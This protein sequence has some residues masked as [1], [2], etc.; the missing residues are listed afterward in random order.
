MNTE[1]VADYYNRMGNNY[2]IRREKQWA[3]IGLLPETMLLNLIKKRFNLRESFTFL[4]IG[5]GYG[6]DLETVRD[7][8]N[9]DVDFVSQAAFE[10]VEVSSWMAEQTRK[11]GFECKMGDFIALEGMQ[12][13][14]DFV[15][16]N[17]CLMHYPLLDVPS[18]LSVLKG[19]LRPAGILGIGVKTMQ[20]PLDEL[21]VETVNKAH[22]TITV[23]RVMTYFDE[24]ALRE[25]LM[26][27]GCLL[28][29]HIAIPS[30][31]PEYNY[32][33]IFVSKD[34]L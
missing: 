10:G 14:W 12:G 30:G 34:A 1:V 19:F 17:M 21:G 9:Q 28:E 2:Q 20:V 23:D 6:A 33:W 16:C 13:Q 7:E 5:C 25:L 31:E 27:E 11:K 3:K 18:A 32:S 4:D 24:I 8:I 15:W 22:D 26:T 29:A